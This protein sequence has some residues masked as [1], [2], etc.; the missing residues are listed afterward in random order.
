MNHYKDRL[1]PRL[2]MMK[3]E[4]LVCGHL[5]TPFINQ[6]TVKGALSE[7]LFHTSYARVSYVNH[8]TLENHWKISQLQ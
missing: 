8:Y 3:H 6:M 2:I 1:Q 5:Q 4:R 7:S